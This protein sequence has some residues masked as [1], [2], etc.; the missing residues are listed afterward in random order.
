VV[1]LAAVRVVCGCVGSQVWLVPQLLLSHRELALAK[2]SPEPMEA[3]RL[4]LLGLWLVCACSAKPCNALA[5]LG[6]A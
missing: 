2:E 3:V 1:K 5:W 4:L 6:V